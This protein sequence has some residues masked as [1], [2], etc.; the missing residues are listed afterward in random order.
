[1]LL[2]VHNDV[3]DIKLLQGSPGSVVHED[4]TGNWLLD[5]TMKS[6]A[7]GSNYIMM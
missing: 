1:M 6:M 7:K 2:L 3:E 5:L 4:I